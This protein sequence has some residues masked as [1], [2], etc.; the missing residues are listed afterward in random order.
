M[1]EEELAD[2]DVEDAESEES[3]EQAVIPSTAA[4][5]IDATSTVRCF[6]RIIVIH[7]FRDGPNTEPCID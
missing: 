1:A 4:V 5:S 7:I 3:S 2:V 6:V